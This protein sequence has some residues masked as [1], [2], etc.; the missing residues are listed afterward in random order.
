MLTLVALLLV[1]AVGVLLISIFMLRF[2]GAVTRRMLTD[3][4]T[5]AEYI[6]EHRRPPPDWLRSRS[7]L[8]AI[9]RRDPPPLD[10]QA[11][12]RMSE[13]QRQ[14]TKTRLLRR[15]SKLIRYFQTSTFVESDEART[16]LLSAL[17]QARESWNQR[18]LEGI[19]S[20]APIS[21]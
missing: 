16:E 11:A 21:P 6:T 4:F 17:E 20:A 18:D 1:F 14:R 8:D 5:F 7:L 2:A 13:R 12:A 3:P 10:T 19:L 9:L 15:L